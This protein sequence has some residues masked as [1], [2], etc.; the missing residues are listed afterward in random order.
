MQ[1]DPPKRSQLIL[2]PLDSIPPRP[3]PSPFQRTNHPDDTD[4]PPPEH[5]L[6]K[7]IEAIL[8]TSPGPVLVQDLSKV[9]NTR[10]SVIRT[11]LRQIR[12]RLDRENHGFTLEEVSGGWQFRTRPEVAQW[13]SKV[14]ESKPI[15]LSKA[16]LEVLSIIAYRQPIVR[17]EIESL[18]G[19]SSSN[20]VKNLIEIGLI[21]RQG[22]KEV[23]GR[24]EQ[25]A[26]TDFF[27]ETFG[28][29]DL[30]DLPTLRDVKEFEGQVSEGSKVQPKEQPEPV[31]YKTIQLFPGIPKD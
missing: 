23:Q 1:D 5:F 8:F 18:R 13:V 15:R 20:I 30:S 17:S 2:L 6:S 11:R 3:L 22:F 21:K 19:T 10:S 29:R 27:L 16:A 24:P 26:T 7:A 9:L 28:L 14:V 4:E 25:F 12:N 31:E